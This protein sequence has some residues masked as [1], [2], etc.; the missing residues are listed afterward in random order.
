MSFYVGDLVTRNSYGNDVIFRIVQ[1]YEDKAILKGVNIRLVADAYTDDL[2]KVDDPNIIT[3]KLIVDT[4]RDSVKLDRDNYFYLP[5]KILHLDTDK[6]YL[7]RCLKFYKDINL[8]AVGYLIDTDITDE[9]LREYLEEVRPDILVLTGH[10]AYYKKLGKVNDLRAYK[11]SSNFKRMI[12]ASRNYEKSQEKL[13][14]IAGACQ[15]CYEELIKA[16]A[17][18]A[19]SPKRIN[20][21]ALDPAVVASSIALTSRSD[22]I[23]LLNILDKTK[24]GPKGMGGIITKGTMY[25]GY[26]R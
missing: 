15:S 18:F 14:I 4:F 1:L 8:S 26:P 2:V 21:H 25:V 6:D 13:V 11:S 16:G 10:D 7:D 24:Y 22:N 19:S 3:D 23:E 12:N 5:G 20:I 17:N 9:E